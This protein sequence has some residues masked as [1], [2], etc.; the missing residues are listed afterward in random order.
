[1]MDRYVVNSHGDR[2]HP[3]RIGLWDPFRIAYMVDDM[4]PKSW[5]FGE[6]M[7]ILDF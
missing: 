7:L 2:F 3:L 5:K 4:K 6:K 1:M